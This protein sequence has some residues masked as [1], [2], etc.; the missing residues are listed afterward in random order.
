MII[1]TGI[2][3]FKKIHTFKSH[4]LRPTS[5]KIRNAIFNILVNKYIMKKGIV[6]TFGKLAISIEDKEKNQYYAPFE[7]V[8]K[9][10]LE[11]LTY[12]LPVLPI[13]F[14]INKEKFSDYSKNIPRY[15]AYN[16]QLDLEF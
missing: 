2:Y 4:K 15:Y 5:N 1:T 16:V 10:V 12:P 3:K 13:K 9:Y 11:Q 7:D 6:K 14:N 8:D